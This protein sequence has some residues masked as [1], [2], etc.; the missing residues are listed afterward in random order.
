MLFEIFRSCSCVRSGAWLF[1]HSS[2]VGPLFTKLEDILRQ[3][4]ERAPQPKT[5]SFNK[6]RNILLFIESMAICYWRDWIQEPYVCLSW[7]H[8]LSLWVNWHLN[9]LHKM[10]QHKQAGSERGPHKH[11]SVTFTLTVEIGGSSICVAWS[12]PWTRDIPN[13][14]L[15]SSTLIS[16][17]RRLPSGAPSPY[18]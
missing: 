6:V 12:W 5:T 11:L 14:S 3:T 15:F 2:P 8:S 1:L 4:S 13:A 9:N 17:S 16:H 18:I 7:G 10:E